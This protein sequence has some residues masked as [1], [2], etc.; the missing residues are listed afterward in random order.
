MTEVARLVMRFGAV[1]VVDG[2]TSSGVW[3]EAVELAAP[4]T[5]IGVPRSV[6]AGL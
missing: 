3:V 2:L 1:T 5:G 6:L 4:F